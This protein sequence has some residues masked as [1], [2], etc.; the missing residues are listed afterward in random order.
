LIACNAPVVCSSLV[1][2]A[3]YS[4]KKLYNALFDNLVPALRESNPYTAFDTLDDWIER[5]GWQ[6][7][8]AC[9]CRDVLASDMAPIA[10]LNECGEPYCCP[11]PFSGDL[12]CAVKRGVVIALSRAQMLGVRNLASLNY[13]IAPLGATIHARCEGAANL[14]MGCGPYCGGDCKTPILMVCPSRNDLCACEKLECPRSTDMPLP[15]TTSLGYVKAPCS[16]MI[17]AYYEPCMMTDPVGLPA[18]VWPGVLAAECIVRSLMPMCS[19]IKI[20]GCCEVLN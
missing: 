14:L 3:I 9:A 15:G 17:Q 4:A 11:L 13:V 7:C 18:K 12:L 6:N 2:H 5:L 19:K 16:R 20:K 10:I 8:Y 1:D